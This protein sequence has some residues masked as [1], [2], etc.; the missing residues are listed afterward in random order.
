[1]GKTDKDSELIR[2]QID[3]KDSEKGFYTLLTNGSIVV[4]K[5]NKYIVP[6]YC[7]KILSDNKI[8]FKTLNEWLKILQEKW[9]LQ[10]LL[11]LKYNDG[12][13]IEPRKFDLVR[14]EILNKFGGFTIAPFSLDGAW[15]DPNSNIKYFDRTKLF[16][17]AIDF[18]EEN[19]Q[20]LSDYKGK[21][22][23]RF[24]QHEIYMVVKP[25]YKI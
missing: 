22:K 10:F 8:N 14:Q 24:R 5:D 19:K 4:S 23:Q 1:M 15:I 20:F 21:L 25:A 16:E 7:M 2:I 11:P 17:V 18:T 13:D 6:A 3:A 9:C 12:S